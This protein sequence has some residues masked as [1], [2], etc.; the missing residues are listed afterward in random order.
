MAQH[1]TIP[2]PTSKAPRDPVEDPWPGDV[3]QKGPRAR[4]LLGLFRR[5][6][7]RPYR[8]YGRTLDHHY[9]RAKTLDETT[10]VQIQRLLCTL[11]PKQT[12]AARRNLTAQTIGGVPF[13]RTSISKIPLSA[14]YKWLQGATHLQPGMDPNPP[15]PPRLMRSL[16]LLLEE[17][18][19]D[20][21]RWTFEWG[22]IESRKMERRPGWVGTFWEADILIGGVPVGT[23]QYLR[24]NRV[25][26]TCWGYA[27]GIL[28]AVHSL[29]R[30]DHEM[31]RLG[32]ADRKVVAPDFGG[33]S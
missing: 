29:D 11:A 7:C 8:S 32:L 26:D 15:A 5:E 21:A 12:A 14:W 31:I 23:W 25:L 28:T 18:T 4:K 3:W 13:K 19:P 6:P 33:A 10:H 16:G 27:Q 1:S 30:S 22:L 24:H 20:G 2:L 9:V 17:K